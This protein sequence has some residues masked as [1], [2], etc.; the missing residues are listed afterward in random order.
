MS[1]IRIQQARTVLNGMEVILYDLL[2]FSVLHL[3]L[4]AIN[5]TKLSKIISSIVVSYPVV[6]ARLYI[7]FMVPISRLL[8]VVYECSVFREIQ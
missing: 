6:K 1:S 2:M 8:V 3:P 7:D 5:T 4:L